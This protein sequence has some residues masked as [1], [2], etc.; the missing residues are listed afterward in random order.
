MSKKDER[1]KKHQWKMAARVFHLSPRHIQMAKLLGVNPRTTFDNWRDRAEERGIGLATYV[2]H[3]YVASFGNADPM[4]AT[5]GPK[6][7]KQESHT[8]TVAR[9]IL[10]IPAE[11]RRR[12]ESHCSRQGVKLA[13]E[14]QALL[15][16]RWPA[17]DAP[18]SEVCPSEPAVQHP[19][20]AA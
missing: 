5:G 2:K 8:R 3:R 15:E 18:T 14:I 1:E 13:E 9:L 19:S 10:Q 4:K 12:M 16:A 6:K 20:P 7:P 17:A 11:L